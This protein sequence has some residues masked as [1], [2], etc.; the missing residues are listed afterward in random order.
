[1]ESSGNALLETTG[2]R[3]PKVSPED[4]E[5]L[6][7]QRPS[8]SSTCWEGC[9]LNTQL[10]HFP[11]NPK[12]WDFYLQG[13]GARSLSFQPGTALKHGLGHPG[14]THPADELLARL[15]GGDELAEGLQG[16]VGQT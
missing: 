14:S 7:T 12:G 3:V 10:S 15:R 11:S 6:G 5:V 1:M 16:G 4:L 8:T 2:V 13:P 9:S